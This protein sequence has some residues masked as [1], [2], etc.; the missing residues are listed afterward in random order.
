MDHKHWHRKNDYIEDQTHAGNRQGVSRFVD[1]VC[2]YGICPYT[3]N[4]RGF[5]DGNLNFMVSPSLYELFVKLTIK[6]AIVQ[7]VTMPK[8]TQVT[9]RQV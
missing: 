5:E 6:T 2:V 8:K 1:V 4:G 3:A 7:A 9:L